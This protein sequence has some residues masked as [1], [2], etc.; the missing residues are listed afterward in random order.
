LLKQRLISQFAI[1]KVLRT[2]VGAGSRKR[3]L[4]CMQG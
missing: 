4:F 1:M 3:L 2:E